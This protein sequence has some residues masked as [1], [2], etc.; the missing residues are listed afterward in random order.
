MLIG[1]IADTH[2]EIAPWS[3]V[4]PKVAQ[5]FAGVEAILHCGDITTHRVL[6][7]LANVARVVAV[8]SAAD[9]QADPP[10]LL[11]GP[12]VL[13]MNGLVIGLVTSL[14]DQD[15]DSLFDRPIDVLV[16]GGTHEPSSETRDGV[17][18]V[19]PGSP[20]L[21]SETT[22]AVLDTATTPPEATIIRL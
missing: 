1:L 21:A 14:V 18:H 7:D 11:D 15:P 6:D 10:R 20:T 8:R 19:N 16:H 3:D 4:F 2:D 5:A 9:P 12:T 17:L 22:V 13:E